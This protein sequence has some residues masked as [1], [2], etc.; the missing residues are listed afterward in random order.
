MFE[1]S[2]LVRE[3]GHKT[4]TLA[5]SVTGQLGLLAVGLAIPL[6]F[7]DQLSPLKWTQTYTLPPPAAPA[8]AEVSEPATRTSR[9]A[10]TRRV[11][12]APTHIPKTIATG[13]DPAGMEAAPVVGVPFATGAIGTAG[14]VFGELVRAAAPPVSQP[15]V[16]AA[17]AAPAKPIQVGGDVQMARIVRRVVPTYPPLARQARISG[18]VR[19][20]GVIGK[21]GDIQSLQVISGHPLLVQAAVSAVRQWLYRPTLLNG[22]PVEVISPIDVVFTLGQP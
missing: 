6:V 7:T 13:V 18:T 4:W 15:V 11:F 22:E 5:A 8:R 9:P 10:V 19:L 20:V 1:R 16:K 14:F 3:S 17:E 2:L 12:V 21:Q